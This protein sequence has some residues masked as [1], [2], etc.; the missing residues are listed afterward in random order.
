MKK[1]TRRTTKDRTKTES[2]EPTGKDYVLAQE[3]E[4]DGLC[5]PGYLEALY[6]LPEGSLDA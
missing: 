4:E 5:E 1:A 2:I 6:G 3:W